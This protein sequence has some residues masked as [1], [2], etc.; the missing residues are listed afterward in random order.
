M[1]FYRAAL[2]LS[3]KTLSYTA[4]ITHRPR[5]SIGSLWRKLNPGQQ[6]LL[7]LAYLRKGETFAELAAGFRGRD[8]H[9]LALHPG[10]RRAAGGQGAETPQGGP[11][12]EEGR[13]R[14]RGAG[15]HPDPDRPG[16]C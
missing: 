7:V 16:R 2:P 4:G 9:R 11:G 15:R 1:L 3:R 6:A 12:R 14:L 10:D 8:G 5:K 13:I